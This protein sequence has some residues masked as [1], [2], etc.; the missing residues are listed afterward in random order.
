MVC[1]RVV[2]MLDEIHTWTHADTQSRRRGWH[3]E[4]GGQV[5]SRSPAAGKD[6]IEKTIFILYY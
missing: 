6:L 5:K 2:N 4:V 1:A 3:S